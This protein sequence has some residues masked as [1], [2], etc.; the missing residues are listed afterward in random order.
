MRLDEHA[1]L[2]VALG[3]LALHAEP[4]VLADDLDRIGHDA[5]AF[6]LDAV[7]FHGLTT[8]GLTFYPWRAFKGWWGALRPSDRGYCVNQSQDKVK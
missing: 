5:L 8:L 1:H 7:G 2:R 6:A 3:A 4:A